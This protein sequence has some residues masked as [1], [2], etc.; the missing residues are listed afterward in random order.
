VY[1]C[2]P[3]YLERKRPAHAKKVSKTLSQKQESGHGSGGKDLLSIQTQGP[4]SVLSITKKRKGKKK[5]YFSKSFC[6]K[7]CLYKS[8]ALFVSFML[9]TFLTCITRCYSY[10]DLSKKLSDVFFWI[11]TICFRFLHVY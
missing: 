11:V 7:N 5:V 10:I 2:N 6:K 3:S 9:Y 8:N 4:D 1:A